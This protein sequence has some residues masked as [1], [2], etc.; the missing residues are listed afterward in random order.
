[1]SH[2]LRYGLVLSALALGACAGGGSGMSGSTPTAPPQSA[3]TTL[4]STPAGTTFN[5]TAHQGAESVDIHNSMVGVALPT[6]EFAA[7]AATQVVTTTNGFELTL[8]NG[9]KATFDTTA[10]SSQQIAPGIYRASATGATQASAVTMMPG[11]RLTYSTYGIWDE[12]TS[13]GTG[14]DGPGLSTY[15]TIGGGVFAYGIRTSQMP[16]TGSATFSG[17]ARGLFFTSSVAGMITDGVVRLVANFAANTIAGTVTNLTT[18]SV[19]GF[20]DGQLNDIYLT[21]G[22]ITGATFAGTALPGPSPSFPRQDIYGATGTFGG[23]FNGPNAVEASGTFALFDG[24][25]RTRIA[26]AFAATG[27]STPAAQPAPTV[28]GP[29]TPTFDPIPTLAEAPVGKTFQGS[30]PFYAAGMLFSNGAQFNGIAA[31]TFT[32]TATGFQF[33]D[34]QKQTVTF[35]TRPGSTDVVSPNHYFKQV[36]QNPYVGASSASTS[37]INLVMSN[38]TYSSYGVWA[39]ELDSVPGTAPGL[40]QRTV[41][42]GV[43]SYGMETPANQ[44]PRTGTA[45]YSGNFRGYFALG[46]TLGA[47]TGGDATLTA[48]FAGNTIAGGITNITTSS[49]LL[50]NGRMNDIVLGSTPMTTNTNGMYMR[51]TATT[52]TA[53]ATTTQNVGALSGD[54]SAKFYGSNAAEIAGAVDIQ[55]GT[56]VVQGGFAAKR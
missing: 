40:G 19:F 27:Q 18:D 33:I 28:P 21:G 30:A 38:L 45:T 16:T 56:T 11:Q 3:P 32:T 29:P 49:A 9:H 34:G 48:N 55:D 2:S 43:L 51:G 12:R 36:A 24:R 42:L 52:A 23:Q 14:T 17:Q 8:P 39:T 50:P 31:G 47:I 7:N 20:P 41:S 22:T 37:Y 25:S 6:G 4:N 35:D 46:S 44:I 54:F 15:G 13:A 53:T 10:G 1:M 26:G 5:A